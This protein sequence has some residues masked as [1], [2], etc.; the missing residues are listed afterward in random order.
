MLK[1]KLKNI[2]IAYDDKRKCPVFFRLKKEKLGHHSLGDA[3]C[4]GSSNLLRINNSLDFLVFVNF[5]QELFGLSA[6]EFYCRSAGYE[7]AFLFYK[8]GF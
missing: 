2:V 7:E 4:F 3:M 8:K 6:K 1:N 5:L